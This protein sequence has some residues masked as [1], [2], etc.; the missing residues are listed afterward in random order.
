MEQA[1]GE[2]NALTYAV[3]PLSRSADW[4]VYIVRRHTRGLDVMKFPS[5]YSLW[6]VSFGELRNWYPCAA[7]LLKYELMPNYMETV[8]SITIGVPH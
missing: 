2:H 6:Q 8:N 7:Y 1:T 3:Q 5:S 4:Q